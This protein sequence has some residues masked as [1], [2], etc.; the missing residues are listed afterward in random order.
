MN[1]HKF[2]ILLFAL[3]SNEL[4]ATTYYSDPNSGSM[5]NSGT[6]ASPWAGLEAIFNTNPTFVAGDIIICLGGNHGFPK[7]NGVN[8]NYVTIQAA[9]GQTPVCSRIYFGSSSV[10]AYWKIIGLSVITENTAT[11]PIRLIDILNT[12]SDHISI[13]GCTISSNLNT[14]SWTRTDWRTKACTGIWARGTNHVI[15]GNT[16]KNIAIGL[17]IDAPGSVCN[18]NTVQNFTIDGIRGNGSNCQY[19][20]NLITDNIV[21]YTYAE[22]HYDGFQAFTSSS[23]D[24]VLFRKNTIIAC[25]DTTRAFRGSMQGMG[26]FDGFYNNWTIENNL[27]ITDH[28]HGITLL[29]AINCRIVNNT[30]VDIYDV[31]PIIS[32]D[33]Q[34]QSS[35][36]PAWIKIASHKNGTVSTGNSILN[37]ICDDMQNSTGIGTIS[38][39]LVLGNSNN[40]SLHFT[41]P[42]N[43]D[44]HLISTSSAINTGTGTFA[45]STDIEGNARPHGGVIDKGAYEYQGCSGSLTPIV[46]ANSACLGESIH[47][48][49]SGSYSNVSWDSG[50]TNNSNNIISSTGYQIVTA[51]DNIGCILK[52]S[53]LITINPLP[54]VTLS[55]PSTVCESETITIN[56]SGANTYTWTYS[57]GT[58]TSNASLDYYPTSSGT[59]SIVGTGVNGCKN[60]ASHSVNVLPLPNAN[61]VSITPSICEGD[62]AIIT[63]TGANS[64]TWSPNVAISSTSG[65][66]N[67]V[68]PSSDQSYVVNCQGTNGCTLELPFDMIVQSLPLV[69][70]T[71]LQSTVCL[72]T[73]VDLTQLSFSPSGGNF[74]GSGV[75]GTDFISTIGIGNYSIAYQYTDAHNCS[76]SATQSITVEDC[77]VG[78]NELTSTVLFTSILNNTIYFNCSSTIDAISLY[79][80]TGKL[81]FENLTVNSTTFE[82]HLENYATGIIITKVKTGNDYITKKLIK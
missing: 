73:N 44:F 15:Q 71:G 29:G 24:N 8:S 61:F 32:W 3:I 63:V 26:C 19:N 53:V 13:Q 10:A 16:I 47:F 80:I 9:P 49:T 25:T 21:V 81:I 20:E 70:F 2:L 56:A 41:D 76:N 31:T 12:S 4:S 7:I 79:D 28:W 74:I 72:G 39:N 57:N 46:S 34:S 82:Y 35:Y 65:A 36:G 45:P 30:V 62:S 22:N 43:Y 14:A 48:N 5:A 52:D 1:L 59:V 6:S 37:N 77:S 42:L 17:I 64:Y 66:S 58:L 18:A 50:L 51:I 55:G 33:S 40:H 75:S 69:T 27:I 78:M 68:Y 38:N 67:K 11:S 23:I 60:S 54:N